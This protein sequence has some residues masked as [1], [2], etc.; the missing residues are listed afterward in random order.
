MKLLAKVWIFPAISMNITN[1]ASMSKQKNCN[2][3]FA[4]LQEYTD[5]VYRT[6]FS[7]TFG[8]MEKYFAPYIVRQNDG[9]IKKAH[10]RDIAP[11]NN[12]GYRLIPQIMAGNAE[13]F[14]YLANVLCDAGYEEINWNLGCP[15]PM[16]TNKGL[17]SGLL[18]K[19]DKIKESL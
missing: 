17:G 9:T 19:P 8:S 11:E 7:A 15:Y 12:P 2:L 4:P 6:A 16:A 3:Y 14:L 13:D 18:P 1:F 5:F 10:L